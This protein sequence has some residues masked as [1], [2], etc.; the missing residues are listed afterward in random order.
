MSIYL[1]LG[2]RGGLQMI[3][4]I[5]LSINRFRS[6]LELKLPISVDN[7]LVALCGQNNVGKT[8][9]LRAINLFFHPDTYDQKIDKPE[10]KIA[11][12]GAAIHPK[13]EILFFDSN[14]GYYYQIVRDIKSWLDDELGLKG[15]RYKVLGKKKIDKKQLNSV[16]ITEFLTKFHF[17]YVE[18]INT[19]MPELIHNL[20]ED[21]IDVEYNKSRF[22]DAK[23]SLK[24]AYDTY[25]DGL[26]EI[27]GAF[28]GQLSETFRFFQENWGVRFTIP[29]NSNSFREL[30]SDDVTL[31]LH[32]NGSQGVIDKGAGLQRL[33]TILLN[34]EMLAKM[35]NKKQVIICIDEPDVYL[36][37]GLQR[38]LKTF[39]DD[40]SQT[41]QLFF[42]THSKIFINQY[43]MNNVFLLHAKNYPQFSARKQKEITVT[44]TFLV[45]T[46]E[47]NGYNQICNHLGIEKSAYD[48]LKPTNFLVEGACDKKYLSELCAYFDIITPNIESMNGADNSEKYLEFYE[49]YYRNNN[50]EYKPQIKLILDNDIKGREVFRKITSK[51]YYN[52]AVQCILLK[53]HQME[54]NF[55]LERNN[56]NNEIEDLLYPELL[57]HLINSLLAKKAMTPLSSRSICNKIHKK[58]FLAKGILE[59]CENEKNDKNP[60]NGAEISFV[61]SGE[62]TNRIKEGLAG[63]FSIQANKKVIELMSKCHEQYPCVKEYLQDLCNF[64]A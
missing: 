19:F 26:T 21:M 50:C 28:S 17:V 27:L 46:A 47:E 35:H 8:N 57:C 23:R 29:K 49:S 61:S 34:F 20:T 2:N 30:I 15:N 4:I 64:D 25:I 33:A 16:E 9:T 12:G 11:T 52:I 32:D 43:N 31:T 59:L 7:N 22:T 63:M 40:K 56:T 13:I 39:F 36:H 53:N 54:G 48:V 62:N 55:E 37:E 1:C 58:S 45:D 42:T 44:E 24:D 41:M 60:E 3:K 51:S 38:K 10:I 5:N 18:S 6:I 14:S